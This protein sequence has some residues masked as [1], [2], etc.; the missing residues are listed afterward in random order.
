M[1]ADISLRRV[2]LVPLDALKPEIIG[3]ERCRWLALSN[4]A[5]GLLEAIVKSARDVVRKPVLHCRRILDIVRIAVAPDPDAGF[6]VDELCGDP[7]LIADTL[8]AAIA[9]IADAELPADTGLF[10]NTTAEA[11]GR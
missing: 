1:R 2:A 5:L 9:E 10:L 6:G 4:V 11:K 8:N 7:E 3:L